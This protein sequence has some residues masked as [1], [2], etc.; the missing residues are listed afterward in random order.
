MKGKT[1]KDLFSGKYRSF[2]Q[3][4]FHAN[5]EPNAPVSLSETHL[6]T[7]FGSICLLWIE[8]NSSVLN[9]I[10]LT[11]Y[12]HDATEIINNRKEESDQ[13]LSISSEFWTVSNLKQSNSTASRYFNNKQRLEQFRKRKW[14]MTRR[15]MVVWDEIGKSAQF[16]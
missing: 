10:C 9:A 4:Y 13:F 8:C 5:D 16:C 7:T 6:G 14:T 1:P 12:V 15:R 2:Q 11:V 3:T